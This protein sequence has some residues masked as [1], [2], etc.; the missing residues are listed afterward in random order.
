LGLGFGFGKSG[1]K[2][3]CQDR[4][5]GDH[6]KEFDQGECGALMPVNF[7]ILG[8]LV[9]AYRLYKKCQSFRIGKT[10]VDRVFIQKKRHSFECLFANL[11]LVDH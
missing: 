3:A 5:N 7:H 2:Q 8:Y 10:A 11:H 6:N 1:Q 9:L 4:D